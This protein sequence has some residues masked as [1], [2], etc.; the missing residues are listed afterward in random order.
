MVAR[1]MPS[2]RFGVY[3]MIE[4]VQPGNESCCIV[5]RSAP[6]FIEALRKQFATREVSVAVDP[7]PRVKV[8][9][10]SRDRTERYFVRSQ[11]RSGARTIVVDLM[12]GPVDGQWR[13]TEAVHHYA[14]DDL[15]RGLCGPYATP[16]VAGRE[17]C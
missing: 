17:S 14:A 7:E 4:P 11:W 6:G 9:G 1:V 12:L 13:W 16:W 8:E 10:P 5:N 3:T 15:K 2:C